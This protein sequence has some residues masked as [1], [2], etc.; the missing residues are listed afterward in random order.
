VSRV[1]EKEI[2][3]LIEKLRAQY[4]EYAEK[5]SPRWFD[6]HAFEDRLQTALRNK[7]DLEGFILAEISNFETIKERYD[8]KKDSNSFSR[9]V[10]SIIEEHAEKI[11]VYPDIEFHPR[12]GF[13]I[14]HMYGALTLLVENHVPILWVIL[15]ERE[16]RDI[17]FRLEQKLEQYGG[18]RG[19]RHAPR[20]EDHVAILKR[21]GVRELDVENDKNRYLREAAFML[22]EVV[23]FCA[24]LLEHRTP[25]WEAPLR[26]DGLHIEGSRKKKVMDTFRGCSG[27][28][29]IV[30]I[31][32]YAEGVINNFRLQ[33]FR[34][35]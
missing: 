25:S 14:R 5:F 7:M 4:D 15:E 3:R 19:R 35:R 20:I 31:M 18:T 17:L 28:G 13:E 2:E 16:H 22:N 1:S 21:P 11:R 12:A 9:K 33:A 30:T 29:A 24:L 8:K 32:D 23:I 10:D 6:R 26:F 34:E 27:Y